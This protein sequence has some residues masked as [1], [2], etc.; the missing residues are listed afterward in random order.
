MPFGREVVPEVVVIALL[1]LGPDAEHCV[2]LA[3][4]LKHLSSAGDGIMAEQYDVRG[5]VVILLD[6]NS[7]SM[8]KRVV[9]YDGVNR[10]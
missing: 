3:G 6:V 2:R 8:G 1:Q 10:Q 9:G 4:L 7:T 5:G